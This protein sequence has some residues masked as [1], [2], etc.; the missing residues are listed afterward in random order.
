M[1]QEDL[2]GL[3]FA[4]NEPFWHLCTPGN[5][6][7]V[8]FRERE[9]Y[10]FGMNAVSLVAAEMRENVRILTFQ[11][12]SNHMHFVLSGEYGHVGMFFSILRKRLVK[13]LS[14]KQRGFEARGLNP[15]VFRVEDLKYL[16][17]VIAYVNRNGYVAD[18]NKTPYSY[19]WGANPYFFNPLMKN[20]EKQYLAGTTIES[21]RKMFSSRNYSCPE[22]YY[23]TRGHISPL[24]Y[25]SIDTAESMFRDAHQYFNLV[26]RQVEAFSSIAQELG[27]RITFTDEEIYYAVTSICR[28]EYNADAPYMLG[29]EG[30]FEMARKMHYDFNASNKQIR[31]ILRLDE[32]VVDSMFPRSING[33][34]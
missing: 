20:E 25:C 27:D 3:E 7:G 10:L 33:K 21:Q 2:C 26:S 11:I 19:P 29:M 24:C 17:N 5:W 23:I 18:R 22:N 16:R 6:E 12:M 13:Y 8:I 9:D 32:H 30:K 15:G 4:R 34:L 14:L 28:K 1:R 31:R